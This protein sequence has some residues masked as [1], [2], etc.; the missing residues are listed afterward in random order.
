MDGDFRSD[1]G[2]AESAPEV[3]LVAAFRLIIQLREFG[4]FRVAP[5]YLWNLLKH[6]RLPAALA[7]EE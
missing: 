4:Y 2:N 7:K 3:L 6:R 1:I 5:Q